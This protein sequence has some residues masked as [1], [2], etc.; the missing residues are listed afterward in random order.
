MLYYEL[1]VVAMSKTWIGGHEISVVKYLGRL[2]EDKLK[3]EEASW[4]P[5][6]AAR[7]IPDPTNVEDEV[8][9]RVTSRKIETVIR[10][11][12]K[13]LTKREGEVSNMC[14]VEE[15]TLT[16]TARKLGISRQAVS[17]YVANARFKLSLRLRGRGIE[18]E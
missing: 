13:D 9:S 3:A 14:F 18:A 11:G 10:D 15:L 5:I 12:F 8:L 17:S 6:E 4:E 2:E 1:K 7:N 16:E